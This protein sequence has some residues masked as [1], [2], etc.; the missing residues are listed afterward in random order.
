M[1]NSMLICRIHSCHVSYVAFVLLLVLSAVSPLNGQR[2]RYNFNPDWRVLVADPAGAE[3]SDFD[4]SHWKPV[5]LPYA[6]NEDAA[7]RVQ[8]HD[9]PT[10]IAWYRKHFVLPAGAEN[11]QVVL[12]FEG[13]RQAA[14]IYLNGKWISRHEDGVTAFGVN[15]T[16]HLRQGENIL[17][18]RT[19]NSWDYREH[20]TGST[21]QWN[22][23]NFYANYGGIPRNVWLHT[24]PAVHQTLPLYSSLG[25]TGV[26]I[27]A[28]D[29]AVADHQARVVVESQVHNGT[30]QSQQAELD[31]EIHRPDGSL[32]GR[33]SSEKADAI[34]P[35]FTT[36]VSAESLLSGLEFWSWGYGY[37][38]DVTTIVKIDGKEVD[39][40]VTRT[41]FR[42]TDFGDGMIY[43]NGRVM[44]VHGYAQRTTNEW[45]SVGSAVPAWMSDF[46][47][48]M[49][50]DGNANLVRWMHVEPW[51]QDVES[52]DRVGLPQSMPAGD[53]EGDTQGRRWQQRVAVMEDAIVY[54]RNNPSILFY[55]SGNKGISAE[56]MAEM[57]AVRDRFDPHGGRAIGAREMLDDHIAE[58]GG[59]MLYTNKSATKP[60]WAHEFNRD[61]GARKFAD[62]NSFPFHQDSPLYNRNQD[63]SALQNVRTWW[64]FY[65][66]RPGTGRRVSSGGVNI[67]F[68]DSNTHYRGDNNYRRSGEVDAMRLPKEGFYADQVMWNGWV[69]P[70]RVMTHIVGHWNYEPGVVK[71][72]YVISTAK[73]I[74][75]VLNGRSLGVQSPRYDFLFTF[76]DVRFEAG[77]LEAFA[78]DAVGHRGSSTSVQTIGS[79]RKLRLTLHTAAEGMH[80]DG[81]D[82]A[83]VD[84]EVVDSQGRRCPLANNQVDFVLTGAAEWRGGIAQ[85]SAA[86]AT[87]GPVKSPLLNEDNFI[88]SRSLPVELGVNRILLRAG[89]SAGE[90]RLQAHA[91]GLESAD[92]HFYTIPI[93]VEHGIAEVNDLSQLALNLERG[94]T[95]LTPSFTAHR[96]Q[97]AVTSVIAGSHSVDAY[98]SIDDNETTSWS[99]G[100]GQS[101]NDGLKAEK[102][103]SSGKPSLR[104]AWIEFHFAQLEPLQTIELKLNGFRRRSY[105]L[106]IYADGR[107]IWQGSTETTL[108]YWVLDLREVVHAK[109]IRVVLDGSPSDGQQYDAEVNGKIDSS[110][111]APLSDAREPVLSVIEADF[112]APM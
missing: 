81:A 68:S 8:I 48:R 104:D 7:F 47:N 6:W 101:A 86:K 41:G 109:S 64:D 13:V 19:D 83:L 50:V 73:R 52:C 92:L 80:A 32:L 26:Y 61:E 96:R 102:A 79:A 100:N 58:Y 91:K 105:P 70:E 76:P 1:P 45:P 29:F 25:T 17:A 49:M 78:V 5:S 22:N 10:G 44:Q 31:V 54:N 112:Y 39:R 56:H 88:L 33:F 97:I 34:S 98:R 2:H 3:K 67:V 38:Y 46:S 43:L 20:T 27:W 89:R 106:V 74:E 35:G 107:K 95:P 18:V 94:P 93:Q 62:N 59:E 57:K 42:E 30:R 11:Q 51:K 110:G 108:G 103:L 14:E 16:T 63:S 53:A 21:Y 65:R 55:E 69:D 60:V 82:M 36:T 72:V 24:L 75:L 12:E 4:D 37:L 9:L 84:V 40:L 111:N 99:N 28:K 15:I 66:V 71:S 85:G 77:L 87:P 23:N 90:V